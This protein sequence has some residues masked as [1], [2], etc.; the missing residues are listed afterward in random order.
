MCVYDAAVLLKII[1]TNVSF[2]LCIVEA[3]VNVLNSVVFRE[4]CIDSVSFALVSVCG[5]HN[6]GRT[7]SLADESNQF[8]F[9]DVL[10]VSTGL[11]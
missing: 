11:R 10:P 5:K 1:L 3:L 4:K 8:L 2:P 7:M 6:E 9:L